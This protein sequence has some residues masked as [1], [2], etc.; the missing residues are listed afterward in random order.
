MLL[1]FCFTL[2]RTF[3]CTFC[4]CS[5]KVNRTAGILG[6]NCHGGGRAVS[7]SACFNS[8]YKQ[9]HAARQSSLMVLTRFPSRY[10]FYKVHPC[11]I[12]FRPA[13]AVPYLSRK[14]GQQQKRVTR[15]NGRE[16][17]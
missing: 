12:P 7:D 17:F 6:E 10:S 15:Q 3:L 1:I 8:L 9:T 11:T 14:Y 5:Q 16:P 4:D 13:K 2:E